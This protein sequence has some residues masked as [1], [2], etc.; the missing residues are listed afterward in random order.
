MTGCSDLA[1]CPSPRRRRKLQWVSGYTGPTSAH[2]RERKNLRL[3]RNGPVHVHVTT[4]DSKK[5]GKYGGVSLGMDLE[6]SLF[7]NEGISV[8]CRREWLEQGGP[9]LPQTG[10]PVSKNL[11]PSLPIIVLCLCTVTGS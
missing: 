8:F 3:E 6:F 11:F 10:H 1:V 9:Q 5:A 7:G 4:L 2:P